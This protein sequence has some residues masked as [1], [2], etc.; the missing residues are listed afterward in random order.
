MAADSPVPRDRMVRVELPPRGSHGRVFIGDTEVSH[1]VRG[2]RVETDVHSLTEIT[3]S[4]GRGISASTAEGVGKVDDETR[5]AL[6]S[7]GWT[8]PGAVA[9]DHMRR[10]ADARKYLDGWDADDWSGFTELRAI[11]DGAEP[12]P[13]TGGPASTILC[14]KCDVYVGFGGAGVVQPPANMSAEWLRSHCW[15][16]KRTADEVAADPTGRKSATRRPTAALDEHVLGVD[17]VACCDGG[18][19]CPVDENSMLINDVTTLTLADLSTML[20]AHR[21]EWMAPR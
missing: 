5:N 9:V 3:L 2:V 11:L 1:V 21:A 20:L 15:M 7:L 13:V 6:V 14:R 16:C 17:R 10:I 19:P 12:A 18:C 4:I 8:A